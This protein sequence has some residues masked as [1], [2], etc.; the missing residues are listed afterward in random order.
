MKINGDDS[1]FINRGIESMDL[2]NDGI[3]DGVLVANSTHKYFVPKG[4]VW[5]VVTHGY[6]RTS[7]ANV[8]MNFFTIKTSGGCS[9]TT[10][11]GAPTSHQIGSNGTVPVKV[12]LG[13][14]NSGFPSGY[15]N[16][17]YCGYFILGC[18]ATT[19]KLEYNIIPL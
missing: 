19:T 1:I 8:G 14:Q 16:G 13:A 6:H 3:I 9:S 2:E 4:S 11:L 15:T 7:G 12:T 10:A 18:N 17:T 5:L